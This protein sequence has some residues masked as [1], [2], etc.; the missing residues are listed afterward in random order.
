[1]THQT[2]TDVLILGGGPAGAAAALTFLQYSDLSVAIVERGNFDSERVGEQVAPDIHEQLAYLGINKEQLENSG[3]V[4]AYETSSAWG[5]ERL[6]VHHSLRNAHGETFQLDRQAFDLM[7]IEEAHRRGARVLPGVRCR[8]F[9]QKDG[10]W[11]VRGRHHRAGEQEFHARFLIDATGRGSQVSNLLGAKIERLD[12]LVAIGAFVEFAEPRSVVQ[13]AL[14]ESVEQGWWYCAA[15]PDAGLTVTLF[16]DAELASRQRLQ[17][18]EVWN[19]ML[20]TTR[21]VRKR[22]AGTQAQGKPWVRNAGSHLTS[23]RLIAAYLPVGDAAAA[24]DPIS[25]MGIGF[26]L[27]SGC[28]AARALIASARGEQDLVDAYHNSLSDNYAQFLQLRS[29]F[30]SLER[31]WEKEPFWSVRQGQ[32]VDVSQPS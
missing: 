32:A 14:L 12:S 21:H 4:R 24:F 29:N 16:T 27:S 17:L 9:I 1:M 18:P 6:T 23:S 30:Y 20:N 3:L 13:G 28:H 5:S 10:G 26:A 19:A 31:R 2:K 11:C 7:L 8:K 22:V 25:S 15:L